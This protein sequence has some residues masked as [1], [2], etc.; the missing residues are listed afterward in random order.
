M[1]STYDCKTRQNATLTGQDR[2]GRKTS[3]T[4]TKTNEKAL[5][6]ENIRS[7][8]FH[9]VSVR[10]FTERHKQT[11]S[12]NRKARLEPARRDLQK[13]AQRVFPPWRPTLT[14]RIVSSPVS[15]SLWKC[16]DFDLLSFYKGLGRKIFTQ[17]SFRMVL[18]SLVKVKRKRKYFNFLVHLTFK[19]EILFKVD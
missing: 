17:I 3:T 14:S 10:T 9:S 13:L 7:R 12:T 19:A 2:Q 5:Q 15:W 11:H 6:G 18:F 8:V 16:S 1:D 4:T